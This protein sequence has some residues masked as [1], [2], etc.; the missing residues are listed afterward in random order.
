MKCGADLD[1]PVYFGEVIMHAGD[2]S[3]DGFGE[4]GTQTRSLIMTPL[5]YAAV[6]GKAATVKLL[7]GLAAN[8]PRCEYLFLCLNVHLTATRQCVYAMPADSYSHRCSVVL[9]RSCA[10]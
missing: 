5:M 3:S 9:A 7:L 8:N 4:A 2:H 10:P 6:S 1:V